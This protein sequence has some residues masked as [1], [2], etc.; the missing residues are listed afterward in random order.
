[1]TQITPLDLPPDLFRRLE[2]IPVSVGGR[3]RFI[4]QTHPLPTAF[5]PRAGRIWALL[6]ENEP[7]YSIAGKSPRPCEP[8]KRDLRQFPA[9]LFFFVKVLI[10]DRR[11]ILGECLAWLGIFGRAKDL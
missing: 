3:V 7:G 2:A 6:G 5:F 8:G 11:Q 9:I 4:A 1:M 10:R